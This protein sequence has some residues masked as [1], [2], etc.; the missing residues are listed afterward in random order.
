MITQLIT[1]GEEKRNDKIK[2]TRLREINIVNTGLITTSE[3]LAKAYSM[4]L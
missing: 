4:N 3:R 1:K 2:I